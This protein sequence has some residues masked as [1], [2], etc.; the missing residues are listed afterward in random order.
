ML[1]DVGLP[2]LLSFSGALHSVGEAEETEAYRSEHWRCL[3]WRRQRVR[4]PSGCSQWFQEVRICLRPP[5]GLWRAD[6][7]REKHE[8]ILPGPGFVCIQTQLQLDWHTAQEESCSHSHSSQHLRGVQ[9]CAQ[10]C[11]RVGSTSFELFLRSGR[12]TRY[13]HWGGDGHSTS[14]EY[15]DCLHFILTNSTSFSTSLRRSCT[16]GFSTGLEC[17]HLHGIKA[18]GRRLTW[19]LDAVFG[20]CAGQLFHFIW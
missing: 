17:W 15:A 4:G 5:G 20:D 1:L 18:P 2:S 6:H 12:L 8:A 9:P 14:S 3:A 7:F 10:L 16:Y 13:T 19:R 11:L